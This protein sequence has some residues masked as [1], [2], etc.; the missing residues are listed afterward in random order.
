MKFFPGFQARLRSSSSRLRTARRRR[1]TVEDMEARIALTTSSWTAIGPAPITGDFLDAP[2]VADGAVTGRVTSIATDP[3][4]A[5]TT[6]YTVYIGTAGGGVWEGNDIH[7]ASP[8]WVPLTDNLAEQTDDPLVTLS[9]GAV[10]TAWDTATASTVIYAGL[11]EPNSVSTTMDPGSANSQF[12]GTGIIKS[13]D[14]GQTWT[15]LG[16]PGSSNIFSRSA[17]SKIVAVDQNDPDIVYAAVSTGPR[18]ACDGPG[19]DLGLHRRRP[20]LDEHDRDRHRRIRP[21]HVLRPGHARPDQPRPALRRGRRGRRQRGQRRLRDHGRRCGLDRAGRSSPTAPSRT[22]S[23]AWAGSPWRPR[24]TSARS[25][26]PSTVSMRPS[27]R[28]T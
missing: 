15:L 2:A 23:R 1:P 22:I 11:G 16:G 10:A 13:T 6:G 26:L 28:T 27:S 18:T 21:G 8:T 5:D 3:N 7:S 25:T 12:Y 24:R 17:I 9:V 20:D 19:G 14:G 4:P